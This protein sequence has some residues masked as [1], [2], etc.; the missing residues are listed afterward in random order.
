MYTVEERPPVSYD[1]APVNKHAATPVHQQVS[2]QLRAKITTGVWPPHFR[3]PAEPALAEMLGISRGTLRRALR[4][5]IA[6]GLLHQVHGRGTFVSAPT[7]EAPIASQFLSIAETLHG[8]AIPFTNQVLAVTTEVA[9]TRVATLL[10]V[11]DGQ[12]VVRIARVREIDSGPVAY[13]LN[14]IRPD[15]AGLLT[16]G[17]LRERSLFDLIEQA[18]GKRITH[19]RRT[20]QAHN[21]DEQVSELLDLPVGQAVQYFEQISYLEDGSPVEHSEV[22][23]RTDRVALSALLTRTAFPARTR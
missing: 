5:L 20:F 13:M 15:G 22:W 8:Q 3:L 1:L 4:T 7:A 2:E 11:P 10:E 21:A 19:G 9:P 17:S 23:L 18:V 6:A 16:A 14:T 12:R